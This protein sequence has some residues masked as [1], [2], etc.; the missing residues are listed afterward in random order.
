[1]TFRGRMRAEVRP[2]LRLAIPLV[3]GEL[4]WMTM[5]VVDTMMVGRVSAEAMGGVSLGS[6]LFYA[7][8]V[9]GL[10]LLLGLDPLV[11]QAFGAGREER[12]HRWLLA[13]LLLSIPLTVLLM[14]VVLGLE[15]LL[16]SLGAHPAV[17][18]EAGPYLRAI[19]WSTGPLL[20]YTALRRYL[21]G[22]NLVRPVMFSLLSANLI[23][24]LANWIF[25]FGHFGFPAMGAQGA[26]WA[27]CVSRVYMAA[28]VALAAIFA[29]GPALR[30]SWFD[31]PLPPWADHRQLLALGFPAAIQMVV[32]VGVFALTTVFIA[33]L[34]PASLAAHQ[35]ALS[36]A[37]YSYMVPLGLGSAAAVR[38]GQAIGRG[39]PQ[40]A[41]TAGWAAI[42][43]GVAFM[44]FAGVFFIAAPGWIGRLFTTDRS[45]IAAAGAL[46]MLAAIWQLFDGAQGVATGALRGAGETRIAAITHLF[47]YWA[48]GL[49][50]GYWLCFPKGWGAPGIW[51]GMCVALTFIG[52]VLLYAWSRLAR[53]DVPAAASPRQI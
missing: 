44:G 33:R 27:T 1:M 22:M 48:V 25:V 11:A 18:A 24:A 14:A 42:L 43:L 50:I 26:G 13:G 10:G 12:C 46:L 36:A 31:N 28:V 39:D 21:Q 4:G 16:G 20:F 53:Q 6:M 47:G 8:A 35:V 45:V 37:S 30:R 7:T 17:R 32:E 15:P 51:T 40:A 5:G 19:A 49:P 3:L 9:F 38:V 41:A 29:H 52:I 2:L 34:D 23:N